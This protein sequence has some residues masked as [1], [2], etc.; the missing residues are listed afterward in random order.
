MNGGVRGLRLQPVLSRGLIA[1]A[2]ILGTT[3]VTAQQNGLDAAG[4]AFRS[5]EALIALDRYLETW[6]SRDG[7]IWATSLHFP[8]VRP[9]AGAFEMTQTPEQYAAG[10]NFEQTLATGWHHS[11][12]VSRDV[13][14]VGVDKVHVAGTWQRYTAD[15][16]PMAG[17]DIT[18]V[19]TNQNG[20]WGIQARFAA[21]V[22]GLDAAARAKNAT[23]GL[24]AV[25]TFV[26]AWNSHDPK[27]VADALHYPHV[28]VADRAVEIAQNAQAYL[29]GADPGRQRTWPQTR[30]D[31][32]TVVQTTANGVNVTVTI[33][34]LGRDGKVL[35]T[36][37]GLFLAVLR[38]GVWKIQ[39]RSMMGS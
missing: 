34:R 10:V 19:V 23:A 30:L 14:Q 6:N 27:A 3:L 5:R 7:K 11:E 37:E 31:K 21:G 20:H 39:A 13:L 24:T 36:D 22:N 12:W 16:K 9:G 25:S 29:A 4:V 17:S 15:D 18:Y 2:I 33:S 38:D 1:V 26:R 28:R 35:S 32:A 8:H